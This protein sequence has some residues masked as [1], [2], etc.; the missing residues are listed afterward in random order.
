MNMMYVV[1]TF[2]GHALDCLKIST[3]ALT[4]YREFKFTD[5]WTMLDQTISICHTI[6]PEL[7]QC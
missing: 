2:V 3:S 4:I 7:I 1:V 6:G 5:L